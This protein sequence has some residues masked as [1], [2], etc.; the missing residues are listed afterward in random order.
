MC[1]QD[2]CNFS[3]SGL[4]TA[5]A[6]LIDEFKSKLGLSHH[7]IILD[8]NKDTGDITCTATLP[9]QPTQPQSANGQPAQPVAACSEAQP[10]ATAAGAGA[11]E[12]GAQ[13]CAGASVCEAYVSAAAD[14][15]A[16]FTHVA[17]RFLQQRTARALQWLKVCHIPSHTRTRTCYTHACIRYTLSGC[18]LAVT[19]CRRLA[20]S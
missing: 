10:A 20:G 13:V 1:V 14:V 16:S 8:Y 5:V 12:G 4:K 7:T 15:A 18:T 3:F 6:K 2:S 9:A 17:V 11:E 19:H